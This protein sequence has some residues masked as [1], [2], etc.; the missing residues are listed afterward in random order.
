LIKRFKELLCVKQVP[1]VIEK[2]HSQTE[3]TEHRK[4]VKVKRMTSQP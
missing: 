2:E 3:T 1:V 4:I